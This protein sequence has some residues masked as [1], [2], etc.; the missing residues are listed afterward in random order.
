M[1][2][3]HKDNRNFQKVQKCIALST[4]VSKDLRKTK[5]VKKYLFNL[6]SKVIKKNIG[7][8][9]YIF[10]YVAACIKIV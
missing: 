9:I 5:L 1:K 3:R 7:E 6:W 8:N 4:L 2:A 10:R